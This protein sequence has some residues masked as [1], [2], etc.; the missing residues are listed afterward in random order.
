MV[1]TNMPGQPTDYYVLTANLSTT[2]SK[3]SVAMPGWREKIRRHMSATT[4][5]DISSHSVFGG[6]GV[7]EVVFLRN[8]VQGLMERYSSEH[9][10]LFGASEWPDLIVN[11]AAAD[12]QARMKFYKRAKSA[13]TAFRGLTSLGELRETLRMLKRPAQGL[14]RG[15]D[16]YLKSVSKRT[17]R[18][19]RNSLNR[20]VSETW[21]ESAFGWGPLISDVKDAGSALNR[22]LNRFASSYTRISGQGEVQEAEFLPLQTRTDY[23]IRLL[24]RRLEVRNAGVRYYGE[25]RSVCE[26]PIQADM[27]LF[28]ASWTDIIPTAYELIPY[29]FLLDYFT[30]VGDLLDAWSFRLVDIAWSAKSLKRWSKRTLVDVRLDKAYTQSV[31]SAFAGWIASGVYTS[32]F[33]SVTRAI[34]RSA[35]TPALPSFRWEMPGMGTKWINMTALVGARN[36]T[37]RQLFQ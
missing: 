1:K 11:Y 12:N 10:Y 21:L 30:N 9:G 16:D 36:R 4:A 35:Q 13:M 3:T 23:L 28:G 22:R 32:K 18:A 26:N 31:V 17:R 8:E 6:Y 19:N 25:V 24:V 2:N 29:S 33:Q 15:L 7:A 27:N 34:N 14:R 37:R 5:R 20:I